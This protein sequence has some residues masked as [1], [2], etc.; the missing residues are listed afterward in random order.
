MLDGEHTLS[1][2]HTHAAGFY[3]VA[4]APF[5]LPERGR[6]A[7]FGTGRGQLAGRIV[8]AVG[9]IARRADGVAGDGCRISIAITTRQEVVIPGNGSSWEET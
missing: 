6:D 1:P 5:I 4:E 9:S 7:G 3:L 8:D 2:G